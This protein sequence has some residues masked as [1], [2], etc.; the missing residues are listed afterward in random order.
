MWEGRADIM[1]PLDVPDPLQQAE[2]LI[3]RSRELLEEAS[4]VINNTA[5][6]EIAEEA[7]WFLKKT[8]ALDP[9][10]RDFRQSAARLRTQ[11]AD[12]AAQV[13]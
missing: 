11:R 8:A 12:L 1:R 10:S 5:T 2:T 3:E 9:R 4:D 7:R 13:A 6:G